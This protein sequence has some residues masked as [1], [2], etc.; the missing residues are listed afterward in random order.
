VRRQQQPTNNTMK[1]ADRKILLNQPYNNFQTKGRCGY[2]SSIKF[3]TEKPLEPFY[4]LIFFFFNL[5]KYFCANKTFITAIIF[6]VGKMCLFLY[7]L[8]LLKLYHCDIS[9]TLTFI[10]S[11]EQTFQP[12]LQSR[13]YSSYHPLGNDKP[14]L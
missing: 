7:K 2:Q 6:P 14:F 5:T 3:P 1:S 8:Q 13:S 9:G 4:L 12:S 10:S 11:M